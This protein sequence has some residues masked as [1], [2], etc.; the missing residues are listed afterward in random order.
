MRITDVRVVS[1][2]LGSSAPV[3]VQVDTDEGI[4]GV[5]ATSATVSVISAL[6]EDESRGDLCWGLW[7]RGRAIRKQALVE[8]VL[9]YRFSDHNSPMRTLRKFPRVY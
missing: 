4:T 3:L 2:V 1:K 9:R 8:R 5:G 7:T 6:I